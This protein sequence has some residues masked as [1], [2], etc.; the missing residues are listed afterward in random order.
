MV[1]SPISVGHN[2]FLEPTSFLIMRSNVGHV[3]F[4]SMLNWWFKINVD[5]NLYF[6]SNILSCY[7]YCKSILYC[8]QSIGRSLKEY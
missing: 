6:S 1:Y 4:K 2:S 8:M 7:F 3:K 5:Q